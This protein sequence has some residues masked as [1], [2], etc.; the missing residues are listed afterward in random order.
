MTTSTQASIVRFD[1]AQRLAHWMTA[2]LFGTLLAT[3]IALYFGSLFGV[4]LDR[5]TIQLIHLWTGLALPAPVVVTALGPWGAR[6]RRDIRQFAF[7]SRD[8][9]R[10]IASMGR[11]RLRMGKFNPGQKLNAVTV[12]GS[13]VV[14]LVSGSML[15]WFRFFPVSTRVA[16]TFVHDWFA[17]ALTILIA[18]HVVVALSHW[19][20]LRSMITGRVSKQWATTHAPAWLEGKPDAPLDARAASEA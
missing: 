6:M 10:W 16:A 8:E 4:V 11:S 18:G 12:G 13:I 14:L 2:A 17:L 5:H 19:P 9:V 15:Q 7:W 20:S 3:G 1:V